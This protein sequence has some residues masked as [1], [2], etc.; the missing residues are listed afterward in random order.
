MERYLQVER[1]TF[2]LSLLAL[3]HLAMKLF[4]NICPNAYIMGSSL[5]YKK[6]KTTYRHEAKCYM[7]HY[8]HKNENRESSRNV[9]IK[10]WDI[11]QCSDENGPPRI[12]RK[13]KVNHVPS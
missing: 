4:E 1:T 6:K 11:T 9:R 10:N 8:M 7:R 2:W 5:Y 12:I 3:N 13:K